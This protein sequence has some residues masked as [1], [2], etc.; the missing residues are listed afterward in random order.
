M[1]HEAFDNRYR[2]FQVS[3]LSRQVEKSIKKL[4]I[5]THAPRACE[6]ICFIHTKTFLGKQAKPGEWVKTTDNLKYDR[7]R[8]VLVASLYRC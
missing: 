5:K 3:V 6:V 7:A 2:F 1:H 8:K 4:P